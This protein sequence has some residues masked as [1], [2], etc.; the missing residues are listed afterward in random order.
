MLISGRKRAAEDSYPALDD[1]QDAR[2]AGLALERPASLVEGAAQVSRPGALLDGR[3][4]EN[5]VGSTVSAGYGTN[6][7]CSKICLA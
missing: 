3:G 1:L 7:R 6:G 4:L 5:D 2:F